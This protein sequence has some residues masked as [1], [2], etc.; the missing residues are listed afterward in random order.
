MKRAMLAVIHTGPATTELMYVTLRHQRLPPSGCIVEH[1]NCHENTGVRWLYWQCIGEIIS[2]TS[3]ARMRSPSLRFIRVIRSSFG[4]ITWSVDR[5]MGEGGW[6]HL[7]PLLICVW[8][9]LVWGSHIRHFGSK[10]LCIWF[11]N[12]INDT[13]SSAFS[14]VTGCDQ[15]NIHQNSLLSLYICMQFLTESQYQESL[16]QVE[17]P[18]IQTSNVGG[19][20][21]VCV[22]HA[23]HCTEVTTYMR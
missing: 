16:I 18:C 12:D 17:Y 20:C 7:M 1:F 11:T 19:C 9:W 4:V 22:N 6:G 13:R 21:R 14:L 23:D 3:V 8:Q 5:R 10:L 2:A 15:R